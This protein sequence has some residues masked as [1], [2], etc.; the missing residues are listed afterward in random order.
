MPDLVE[1]VELVLVL[2]LP[3]PPGRDPGRGRLRH[4]RLLGGLRPLP[5]LG[6][7]F[8]GHLRVPW[9]YSG[10]A[11]RKGE[12]DRRLLEWTRQALCT[13]IP[14]HIYSLCGGF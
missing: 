1:L 8:R 4:S 12:D 6:R 11:A 3:D 14:R 13:M 2:E 9:P 10:R 7:G 5:F